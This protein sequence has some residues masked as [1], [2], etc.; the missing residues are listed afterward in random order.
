MLLN[1]FKIITKIDEL[2]YEIIIHNHNFILGWPW[3][4]THASQIL[5]RVRDREDY[6]WR[7]ACTA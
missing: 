7:S 4:L 6:G 2:K 3:G 1:I 5:G